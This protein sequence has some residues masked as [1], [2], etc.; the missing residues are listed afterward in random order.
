MD[1]WALVEGRSTRG[2][3]IVAIPTHPTGMLCRMGWLLPEP[4]EG[5]SSF[6]YYCSLPFLSCEIC[7]GDAVDK[8]SLATLQE[9]ENIKPWKMMLKNKL[10]HQ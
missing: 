2:G 6:L 10:I 9:C 4:L 5:S 3:T 1:V 8:K 7:P